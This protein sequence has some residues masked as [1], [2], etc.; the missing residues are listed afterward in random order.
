MKT[1][2]DRSGAALVVVILFTMISTVLALSLVGTSMAQARVAGRQLNLEKALYVAESGV[3]DAARVLNTAKGYLPKKVVTSGSVGEGDYTY[4]M[5]K[6]AWRTYAVDSVGTVHGVKRQVK[7]DRIYLP[8]FAK[9]ALWMDDN[10]RIYFVG[11]E[12]FN[13]HV[14]SNDMLW[15]A[16]VDGEGPIFHAECSS[17]DDEYGGSIEDCVFDKGLELNASEG[18]LA[19]VDFPEL[20]GLATTYGMV[21]EGKTTIDFDGDDLLIT[22]SRKGWNRQ[23]V[24]I[25]EDQLIYVAN[26]SSGSNR[27]GEVT[28]EGG[29]VDGRLTIA[30]EGDI[31]I[32]DHIQYAQDPRSTPA[33]DDALGL[34]SKDDVW[35]TTSAPNNL[36]IHAAI[37]AT[38]QEGDNRGSFGV[39]DYDRGSPKGALSVLGSIVQDQR[40]AVGTFRSSG[41][42]SGY[43]KDYEFDRRFATAAPPYYPVVSDKIAFEG[44][45]EGPAS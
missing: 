11:G 20:R 35:V 43:Y 10:G 26:A 34:I 41:M 29:K 8:T 13:G 30:S 15:F 25:D 40:G 5:T 38:G 31:L 18:T 32:T 42:Q 16:S 45:S 33:S 3:E 39:I 44:W 17:A 9:Y 23:R 27:G 7:I 22:N 14:H 28:L 6:V 37:L 4:T 21:L 19:D 2:T 1:K 24:V 36:K 12:E